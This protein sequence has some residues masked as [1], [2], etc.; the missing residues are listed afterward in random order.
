MDVERNLIQI[1]HG[2][3]A[4]VEVLPLIMVNLLQRINSET[5]MRDVIALLENSH[6]SSASDI[7]GWILDQDNLIMPK[8]VD[9]YALDSN[10]DTNISE[11]CDGGHRQVEQVGDENE[12][13]DIEFEDLVLS[14][15]PQQI[16]QLIL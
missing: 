2:P 3:R 4:N 6:I 15:G 5:L 8:K 12:F 1:R 14:E 16:L 11:P 13:R 7:T 10:T 9:A